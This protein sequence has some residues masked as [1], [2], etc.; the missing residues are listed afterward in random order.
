MV[1]NCRDTDEVRLLLG[2]SDGCRFRGEFAY[3]RLITAMDHRQKEFVAQ[4]AVQQVLESAWIGDW[5]EWKSYSGLRKCTYPVWRLAVMPV[6]VLLGVLAPDSALN[7]SNRLPINRM[8]NAMVAYLVFLG[9]LFHQSAADKFRARRGAPASVA[10]ALV[11]AFVLGH[12]VDKVR[13]RAMQGPERFF[14]NAWNV[15]DTAKL[16]LF[17]AAYLCWAM[18]AVQAAWVDDDVARKFWHWADPQLLAEGLFAVAT[19][20]AYMRLLFL[21]QLNYHIGPMQVSG[22]GGERAHWS[23]GSP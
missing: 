10:W 23:V 18:A 14:G 3:P 4:A 11:G 5:V 15:F 16:A 9:L 2:N 21:C 13:L 6:T 12:A 8:I 22:G 7:R 20:M 19:V 17:A 1:V